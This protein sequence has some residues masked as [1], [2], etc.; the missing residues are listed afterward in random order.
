MKDPRIDGAD[1]RPDTVELELVDDKGDPIEEEEEEEGDYDPDGCTYPTW[2]REKAREPEDLQ[3]EQDEKAMEFP[4]SGYECYPEECLNRG[5][6]QSHKMLQEC[7]EEADIEFAKKVESL[8]PTDPNGVEEIPVKCV[9]FPINITCK[10]VPSPRESFAGVIIQERLFIL[11]GYLEKDHYENDVWYRDAKVP[12]ATLTTK[13]TTETSEQLFTYAADEEGCVF[14]YRMFK[15]SEDDLAYEEV[16]RNWTDS[17]ELVYIQDFMLGPGPGKYRFEVRAFDPA[18]NYDLIFEEGRNVH[19]WIYEPPLPVGLIVG[20]IL[21]F[22]A[23]VG[24]VYLE[25]RRRKKKAAMERYAIKR[26]RRKF[27]G[28]QKGG[29]KGKGKKKKKKGGKK[30]AAGDG[31]NPEED[32]RGYYDE[33]KGNKGKKKTKKKKLGKKDEDGKKKK[34]KKKNKDK[35]KKKK[36]K[37]SKK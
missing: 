20:S 23:I 24:G 37:K 27:K 8:S 13:P 19:T 32:W 35:D 17:L 11:G 12:E 22:F 10:L 29:K 33:G 30:T 3:M 36:K 28:V 21:G 15:L 1:Q 34:K 25:V 18:G 7:A 16:V 4:V 31:E 9:Q 2:L 26:M 14:Q 5:G 6:Y